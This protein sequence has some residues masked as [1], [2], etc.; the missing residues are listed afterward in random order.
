[1]SLPTISIQF[2][3]Q[4]MDIYNGTARGYMLLCLKK[5]EGKT[6]AEA[7]ETFTIG[8]A[9]SV[10]EVDALTGL[11]AVH[12]EMAKRCFVSGNMV[13]ELVISVG[14]A[15]VD[16]FDAAKNDYLF[17][18]VCYGS[19]AD[20]SAYSAFHSAVNQFNGTLSNSHR[21]MAIYPDPVAGSSTTQQPYNVYV[22]AGN[23]TLTDGSTITAAN[24]YQF[25]PRVCAI[26]CTTPITESITFKTMPEIKKVAAG[27]PAE[28]DRTTVDLV[29]VD[30]YVRLSKGISG[31]G[32]NIAMTEARNE[33]FEAVVLTFRNNFL[34]KKRNT[35]ENEL[36][37]CA[38]V[39]GFLKELQSLGVVNP[40]EEVSCV[41]DI[42]AMRNAHAAYYQDKTDLWVSTHPYG[43]EVYIKA[44]MRLCDI[45]EDLSMRIYLGA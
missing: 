38:Q 24:L 9:H 27:T 5:D 10:A 37:F 7:T 8:T 17:S 30:G 4:A 23:I 16:A 36:S 43:T 26:C 15:P 20:S 33:I 41:Q 31:N 34:G 39:I 25:V 35:K 1:M 2:L 28:P 14:T 13:K 44:T 40:D 22:C 21:I 42:D 11:C 6:S 29:T 19:A 18:W 3:N 45:M 32:T 12:K